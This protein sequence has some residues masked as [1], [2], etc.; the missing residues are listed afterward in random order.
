M[1][2]L[3]P[4]ALLFAFTLSA[5]GEDAT[6]GHMV[7]FELKDKSPE[8]KKKLVE[9]C[10]KYLKPQAGVLYFSSGERGE[11]FARDVNAKDWDVALHLVFKDKKALDVYAVDPQHLK[12]IEE[13]KENWKS[14]K[15][16][17]SYL[18]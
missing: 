18:K 3:A 10:K 6:V 2:F 15:V 17:D 7:F 16:Y 5:R 1:R 14:V 4:F 11:E 12:F 8:A 9:A 13:N